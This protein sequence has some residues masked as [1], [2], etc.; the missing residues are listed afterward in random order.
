MKYIFL[1]TDLGK[2]MRN[3]QVRVQKSGPEGIA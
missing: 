3:V 2:I 1:H